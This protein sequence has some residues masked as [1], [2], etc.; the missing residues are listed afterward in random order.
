[1]P[2]KFILFLVV[3]YLP[4]VMANEP[5]SEL[6]T[7]ALE[8]SDRV[9]KIMRM[10]PSTSVHNL[11]NSK[12]D[13]D[14]N[15]EAEVKALMSQ[16]EM[17]DKDLGL[18]FRAGY[19]TDN[20]ESDVS[21]EGSTYLE[22]SWDVLRNG[23]K[24]QGYKAQDKLRQARI[25][26]LEGELKQMRLDYNCRNLQLQRQFNGLESALLNIKLGLMERVYDIERKAYFSNNSYL[27]ELLNSEEEIRL[28][29][30]NLELLLNDPL[31]SE[32]VDS[33][34]NPPVIDINLAS[35]IA[36]V[37]HDDKNREIYKL[38]QLRL[39][40]EKY[41]DERSSRLRLFLRKEFDF[42][43]SNQD[44]LVAGLRF[45]MP[46]AFNE[47]QSAQS[48]EYLLN[49]LEKDFTYEQWELIARV[50]NAYLSLREQLEKVTKQQYRVLKSAE[51]IRRVN[52]YLAMDMPLEDSAV[53][54]RINNYLKSAI[55]LVQAKKILYQRVNQMFLVARVDFNPDL[56][57]ITELNEVDHRARKHQRS[58]YV[59]S[60]EFNSYSNQQLA[61]L[62]E[63]KSIKELLVSYSSNT[64]QAKLLQFLKE[65]REKLDIGII[66]GDNG[67]LEM[68]AVKQAIEKINR[69]ALL[70][71]H[72]HLDIEP[73]TLTDFQENKD[74]YL[75]RLLKLVEAARINNPQIK[76]TL[77]VPYHWPATT[78]QALSDYVDGLYV[79]LYGTTELDKMVERVKS[80]VTVIG[81]DKTT[82]ALR[83]E[84][85]VTEFQL[86]NYL[87]EIAQATGVGRFAIHK[88]SV[89]ES[90]NN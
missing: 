1:M 79:M 63:T 33:I 60:D 80:I 15:N 22:L 42:A 37:Q 23:Y 82:I 77:S 48:Q 21:G 62:L 58:V 89:F 86:E 51:K 88:L 64:N 69:L 8:A 49:Q 29:R 10:Q 39:R 75:G 61:L 85:I 45:Q 28:T 71:N 74:V 59:W 26:S 12:C 44:G 50:R 13:I 41:D 54:V 46:L 32:P 52:S 14:W 73:H 20:L 84:D 7:E 19:T 87:Q 16:S 11:F 65:N 47:E 25:K 4:N 55:E 9:A 76:L 5:D 6:I 68:G 40:D 81:I 53:V 38:N 24:Q 30:M 36:L 34:V 57:K 18:E 43:Q 66:A 90:G 17:L 27:D 78:Y 3:L 72:I 35:L 83:A 70:T 2:L 31:G 67:W 56:L